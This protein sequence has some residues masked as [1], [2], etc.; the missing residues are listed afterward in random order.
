M[1]KANKN[2]LSN[3]KKLPPM[4]REPQYTSLDDKEAPLSGK[5][6]Q[7]TRLF[8]EPNEGTY[9]DKLQTQNEN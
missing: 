9:S 8:S 6:S 5:N 1:K 4:I 7:H 3:K 2:E